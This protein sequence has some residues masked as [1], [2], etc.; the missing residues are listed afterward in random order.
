MPRGQADLFA[1]APAAEVIPVRYAAPVVL[2]NRS[3]AVAGLPFRELTRCGRC[4]GRGWLHVA[5]SEGMV[6]WGRAAACPDCG[7]DMDGQQ[8][9]VEHDRMCR[10]HWLAAGAARKERT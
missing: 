1:P 4:G 7:T 5:T 2:L 9:Q 10:C 8:A 6:E 3:P